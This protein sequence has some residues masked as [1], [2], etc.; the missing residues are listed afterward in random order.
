MYGSLPHPDGHHSNH[1]Q[2]S[3]SDSSDTST[4]S[5]SDVPPS[6]RRKLSSIKQSRSKPP[7]PWKDVLGTESRVLLPTTVP[8]NRS[9]AIAYH[10]PLLLDTPEAR[11]ALLHWFDSVS[12]TRL[13]PWRQPWIDPRTWE[14]DATE[15]LRAALERRAYEVWISE[16]MLQ[17]T[18]VAVVI[19]Y[20]KRWM[21]K[22]PTVHHLAKAPSEDVLSAWRGLGYYSRATRIHQAAQLV[23]EDPAL[24][25]L[26][27]AQAH[28]L[29]AKVP[30]IGPYTAGAISAIVFGHPEAMVDGNVIR[31]LSRQMGVYA[32]FKQ[33]KSATNLIW[34][35]ADALAKALSSNP[36]AHE[37][38]ATAV[39][40]EVA[41]DRPGRWG[42]A[43]MELGSTV[44]A[45]KPDCG[46]CPI[47]ST[48]RAFAEGGLMATASSGGQASSKPVSALDIEDSC[49][50]CHPMEEVGFAQGAPARP[51]GKTAPKA[52]KA[53]STV[54]SFF[55]AS[56]NALGGV[57]QPTLSL[58]VDYARRFPVKGIKKTVRTEESLVCAIRCGDSYLIR[59]R[60]TKGL[61]ACLWELPSLTVP[62]G[63]K[64]MTSTRKQ[65]ARSFVTD[66]LKHLSRPAER[67]QIRHVDELGS[68]PWLFS[69]IKLTMHVHIFNLEQHGDLSPLP[70]EESLWA[71]DKE[72]D[73]VTMGTGMRK[74]W[75][76][77][78][79]NGEED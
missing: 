58:V 27:P 74:C 48:C 46:R 21:A 29:K 66:L 23:V 3:D 39:A 51:P 70:K 79:A 30:G 15:S 20:W 43:L 36:S 75:D 76:M 42:Q 12:S 35:A 1:S 68:V 71:S 5:E 73:Q 56:S 17:Q 77:V 14:D 63:S 57:G 25:G 67:L 11:E 69:H 41:S 16:I 44:C 65:M 31:V 60:P 54:S 28:E 24:R 38:N 55:G 32:D 4:K 53:A 2:Q 62:A 33:S 45:P 19:D 72:I 8:P 37:P 59:R 6:K 49:V 40:A 47:T 9:H 52:T 78:K 61:L 7:R 34:D 26:L 64:S 13:M 50:I 10:R 22:W 18:R